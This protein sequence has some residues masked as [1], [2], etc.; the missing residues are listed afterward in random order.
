MDSLLKNGTFRQ[1]RTI[2]LDFKRAIETK[3][4]ARFNTW[5]S[6]CLKCAILPLRCFAKGTQSDLSAIANAIK[7]PWGNEHVAYCTS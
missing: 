4:L 1:S 7:T 2:A 5:R 3:S 6:R